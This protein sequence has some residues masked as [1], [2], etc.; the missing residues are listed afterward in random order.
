MKDIIRRWAIEGTRNVVQVPARTL[1]SIADTVDHVSL[2]N[3]FD[4]K[5]L[6]QHLRRHKIATLAE[7]QH[8]LGATANLTVSRKLKAPYRWR[9]RA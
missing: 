6:R 2:V 9:R 5:I 3:T 1:D 4:P 7:L 8:A